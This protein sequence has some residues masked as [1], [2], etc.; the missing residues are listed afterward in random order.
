MPPRDLLI[1]LVDRRHL[2]V[3]LRGGER[4]A[5]ISSMGRQTRGRIAMDMQ[6]LYWLSIIS[7]SY[8]GFTALFMTLRQLIG[9]AADKVVTWSTRYLIAVALCATITSLMPPLLSFSMDATSAIRLSA[10][11]AFVLMVRLDVIF[12]RRFSFLF[13]EP[14]GASYW[15]LFGL[16]IVADLIFGACALGFTSKREFAAF[17][18][19]ETAEVAVM[20]CYFSKSLQQLIPFE[21]EVAQI[22]AP[23]SET[24]PK[25]P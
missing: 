21:W 19:A 12:I 17:T 18:A 14:N 22:E 2:Q 25:S 23:A 6:Y 5:V 16:A 11:L 9:A 3:L 10:G 20:F 13:Q 1:Q 8:V 15:L 4:L 7:S 24:G